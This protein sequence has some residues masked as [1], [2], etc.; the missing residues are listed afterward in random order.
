MAVTRPLSPE[1]TESHIRRGICWF[2]LGEFELALSDFHAVG[3][4]PGDARPYFW[5]GVIHARRGDH[6]EAIRAYSE[7]IDENSRYRLAYHNR[8]LSLMHLGH[9]QRAI[10]DC[11]AMI[12]LDPD[13]SDAYRHRAL[14]QQHL[15]RIEEAQR[16]FANA[17]ELGG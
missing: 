12:Q 14:A 4:L 2:H 7:A 5:T 6:L 10:D 17:V 16:S 1:N 3:L 15:G 8:A 13:D 9:W 11:N